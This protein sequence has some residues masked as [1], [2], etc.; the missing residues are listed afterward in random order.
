M[1]MKVRH[2]SLHTPYQVI[3]ILPTDL[4]PIMY[5]YIAFL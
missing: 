5:Y 3:E 2:L 1:K 4:M